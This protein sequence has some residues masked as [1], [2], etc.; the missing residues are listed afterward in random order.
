MDELNGA[1]AK[2]FRSS[3]RQEITLE[4]V[5]SGSARVRR[6]ESHGRLEEWAYA[7]EQAIDHWRLAGREPRGGLSGLP[8]AL[9]F[10]PRPADEALRTLDKALADIRATQPCS[11]SGAAS[12]ARPFRRGLG[13]RAT[14][15]RA[16]AGAER[17]R[18]GRFRSGRD[19]HLRGGPGA[20]VHWFRR[21]C[22]VLGA[23][24]SWAL[25]ST[26]A[27]K[28]GRSL[29]ELGRYGEAEPLA[30]LGRELGDDRDY[31]TQMYWRQVKA[32]V[33]AHRGEHREAELL[34][35]ESVQVTEATDGLGDQGDAT[36]TWP[37][38]GRGRAIGRGGRGARALPRPLRAE[39]EPGHGRAGEAEAGGAPCARVITV[40]RRTPKPR[41]S[42]TRAA[43]RSRPPAFT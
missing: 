17:R 28:L 36:T 10:G 37:G 24:G 12:D 5:A 23:A 21:T 6:C 20:A 42:A 3:S 19:R 31:V 29:C 39:E 14:G 2:R 7:A 43:P 32:L 22:A 11:P 16:P 34:A 38:P 35:R 41:G 13:G 8:T 9:L 4:R 27:P 30:D 40:G 25:L 1:V 26:Y 15:R 18:F 33:L